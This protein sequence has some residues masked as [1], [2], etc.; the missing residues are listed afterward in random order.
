MS[1]NVMVSLSRSQKIY[2][3]EKKISPSALLQKVINDLR[4]VGS[5][6]YLTEMELEHKKTEGWKLKY[7]AM[8]QEVQ[9][10]TAKQEAKEKEA[11]L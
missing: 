1:E 10:Y 6:D 9:K 3:E 8:V 2:L 7:F 4:V 11:G 5:S